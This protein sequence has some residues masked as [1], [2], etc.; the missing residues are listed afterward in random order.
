[1]EEIIKLKITTHSGEED[2]VE[3][4]EYNSADLAK[5]LNDIDVQSIAIGDHVYSRIDVKNVK[6][7]PLEILSENDI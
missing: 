5:S 1:M 3:V 4:V 7:T 6:P 2:I